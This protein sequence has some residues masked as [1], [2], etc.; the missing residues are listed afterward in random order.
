MLLAVDIIILSI[1]AL[2]FYIGWNKGLLY[3]LVNIIGVLLA[4]ISVALLAKPLALMLTDSFEMPRIQLFIICAL[5]IFFSVVLIFAILKRL[6]LSNIHYS[7]ENNEKY[8]H[9]FLSR[10]LGG[11][12]TALLGMIVLSIIVFSY[13]AISGLSQKRNLDISPSL[14]AK[15]TSFFSQKLVST[16]FRNDKFSKITTI[17]AAK[18]RLAARCFKSILEN[19]NFRKV[20]VNQE[21]LNAAATG[22][23]F[24]LKTNR[25]LDNFARDIDLRKR[26]IALKF[27]DNSV[28]HDDLKRLVIDKLITIGTRV[29]KSKK[30]SVL[31]L[32]AK[33]LRESGALKNANLSRLYKNKQFQGM[34]DTLFFQ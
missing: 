22:D 30:V 26:L 34:L 7:E 33:E 4:Y 2:Y 21:V 23:R 20:I 18:P 14:A 6:M 5:S 31:R 27:I 16:V 17:F 13:E 29:S 9:T 8:H 11:A 1:L 10:L 19:I 24:T 32:Q 3:A 28:S 25:D 15:T 12:I